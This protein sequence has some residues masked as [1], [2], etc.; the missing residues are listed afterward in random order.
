MNRFGKNQIWLGTIAAA[1]C[2]TLVASAWPALAETM[3]VR[4]H[5]QGSVLEVPSNRYQQSNDSTIELPVQRLVVQ[6]PERFAG[7]WRGQVSESDL[8]LMRMLAKPLVG[9]WLTK[10]YRVCFEREPGGLKARMTD[11]DVSPYDAVLEAKSVLA[12]IFASE[13]VIALSGRLRMVERP[14]YGP[15]DSSGPPGIVDERVR[16]EADLGDDGVM[17]VRGFVNGYYNGRPWFVAA[18][19]GDFQLQPSP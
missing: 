19:S 17:R 13:G 2:V 5:D 14:S 9:G 12:P 18:W 10:S 4:Q 3:P 7:C 16:L 8:T 6:I 1:I 15:G 11:S